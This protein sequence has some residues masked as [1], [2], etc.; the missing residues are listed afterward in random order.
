MRKINYLDAYSSV[1]GRF[2]TQITM[3]GIKSDP[4]YHTIQYRGIKP[5]CGIK[6]VFIMANL[7]FF[8]KHHS[9]LLL[10]K[11]DVLINGKPQLSLSPIETR[12]LK[13]KEGACKIQVK[14]RFIKSNILNLQI[15]GEEEIYFLVYVD[16]PY[17][18]QLPLVWLLYYIIPGGLLEITQVDKDCFFKNT[19]DNDGL[20]WV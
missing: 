10:A 9:F 8:R 5:T 20:V 15:D 14:S 6:K 3:R 18:K 13:L 11:W 7:F 4:H 12:E 19:Q 16:M 17:W 1:S 2:A